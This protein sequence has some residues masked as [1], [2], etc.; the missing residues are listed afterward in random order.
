MLEEVF[1]LRISYEVLRKMIQS[2]WDYGFG[3]FPCCSFLLMTG[4]KEYSY[5]ST[6]LGVFQ[7]FSLY[8]YVCSV[9]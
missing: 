1:N 6:F 3:L 9:I 4:C 5:L 7:T 8:Y 2:E